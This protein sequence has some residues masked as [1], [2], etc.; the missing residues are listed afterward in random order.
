MAFNTSTWGGSRRKPHQDQ[1]VHKKYMAALSKLIPDEEE[2]A[3]VQRQLRNYT[4]N[5]GPFRSMH[6]IN[7]CF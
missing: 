2:A 5:T 4:L 6:A 3:L 7:S 1:E